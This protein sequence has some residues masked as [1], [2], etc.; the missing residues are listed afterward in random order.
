MSPSVGR[1]GDPRCLAG[2]ADRGFGRLRGL[3]QAT[4]TCQACCGKA[5]SDSSA[6]SAVRASALGYRA[7]LTFLFKVA[8][9]HS[10]FPASSSSP[11][12]VHRTPS[13]AL[14]S[15]SSM[16]PS[17]A[18]AFPSLQPDSLFTRFLTHCFSLS[19]LIT[20]TPASLPQAWLFN[21]FLVV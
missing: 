10:A 1:T 17:Q 9:T 19:G 18:P 14:H 4:G 5:R 6:I 2:A 21:F 3:L 8:L 15:P 16:L 20:F 13:P 7:G 12:R 11:S